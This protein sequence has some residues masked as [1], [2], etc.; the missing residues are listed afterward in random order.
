MEKL[1]E[2]KD[3]LAEGKDLFCRESEEKSTRVAYVDFD[4]SDETIIRF[5]LEGQSDC[6][7]DDVHN[8]F[9]KEKSIGFQNL[10]IIPTH[11]WVDS[12]GTG[13]SQKH[14]KYNVVR[15]Y[16][17]EELYGTPEKPRNTSYSQSV[18]DKG[19]TIETFNSEKNAEIFLNALKNQQ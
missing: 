15:D 12:Y 4:K 17:R 18:I 1:Q 6:Y 7:V 19:L 13:D 2:I 9:F 8:F 10:R 14:F 16:F 5:R 3:G 11:N